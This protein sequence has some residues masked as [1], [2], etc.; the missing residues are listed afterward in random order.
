MQVRQSL[1]EPETFVQDSS[2]ALNGN[3]KRFKLSPSNGYDS[4]GKEAFDLTPREKPKRTA[5]PEQS[6]APEATTPDAT[7]APALQQLPASEELVAAQRSHLSA[8]AEES[9]AAVEQDTEEKPAP[10]PLC[11]E[12]CQ[13]I[14]RQ[15]SR[16]MST[17]AVTMGWAS[18]LRLALC[19]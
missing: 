11:E 12:V 10:K 19:S 4:C 7:A 6:A 1:D 9:V 5:V 17:L 16:A 14:R 2:H 8:A 15:K 13:L 18:K 3:L